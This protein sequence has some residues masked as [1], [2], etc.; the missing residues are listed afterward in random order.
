MTWTEQFPVASPPA[1]TNSSLAY[2]ARIGKVVLFGGYNYVGGQALNDTW[3][4][5]GTTWS[6]V[7]TTYTPQGRYGSAMCYDPYFEGL[8]L[9]GGYFTGGPY[10]NQTWL[11]LP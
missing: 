10:T 8:V 5:N 7:Q 2:E 4:W 1:R 9:F 6:Q 11:L 3:T